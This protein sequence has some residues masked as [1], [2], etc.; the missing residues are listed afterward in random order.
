MSTS[1]NNRRIAKNT[2]MLYVRT[3][4]LMLVSLYTSRVTL[5][6]LGET[7]FGIYNIVGG[8][9]ALLSFVS[10]AMTNATQRFLSVEI[11]KNNDKGVRRVYM[12]SLTIHV[13]LALIIAILLET[14]GLWFFEAK[15]NIPPESRDAARWAF[16]ISVVTSL[17]AL[18]R[19]P[20]NALIVSYERMSFYAY[21]SIIEGVLNLAVVFL[22][23]AKDGDRL[24]FYALLMLGVKVAVNLIYLF[25]CKI[26]FD[27]SRGRIIFDSKTLRSMMSFSAWSL[28][29]GV[30][31][32]AGTHGVNLLIN[33]FFSV[34]VNAAMGIATQVYSAVY[35][36]VG[37]FQ[38]AV[39][40][41]IIKSWASG[42]R[43][44]F[45]QLNFRSSKL[46]FY[47][48][49]FLAFPV[50]LVCPALMDLWLG[51]A[52]AH[53]ASFVRLYLLFLMIDALS[54][55]LWI[56]SQA[57]GKIACYQ[58]VVSVLI[59]LNL[60]FIY[61]CFS[62]GCPPEAAVAIRI[63]LNAVTH[64][65]RLVYLKRRIDFPVGAYLRE[66]MLKCFWVSL[67]IVPVPVVILNALG[68]TLGNV[69][70]V[71]VAMIVSA[72]LIY[73]YGLDMG[74]RNYLRSIVMKRLSKIKCRLAE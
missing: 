64:V 68:G 18:L 45:L 40:P 17:F 29:G 60:P 47:L 48:L 50:M 69:L 10:I 62:L 55:P 3:L 41:Q 56:S 35:M 61:I 39:N 23:L 5:M 46:S 14:V 7:D 26:K 67:L 27:A 31:N 32:V 59:V 4:V 6:T 52:P 2:M 37:N 36:F 28:F 74:E 1:E 66:V 24:V 49:F 38:T 9:I 11:G 25:Y 42:E 72:A 43:S 70:S 57:I 34:V 16:H 30:A 63:A 65:Y 22:L 20:D 53:T 51:N 19:I 58:V 54:G 8:F 73:G 33:I 15:M 13:A 44:Q 21:V 12:T 71:V